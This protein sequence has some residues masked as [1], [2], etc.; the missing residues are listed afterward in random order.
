MWELKQTRG[1]TPNEIA[2]EVSKGIFAKKLSQR[3]FSRGT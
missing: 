3:K 2:A 1:L